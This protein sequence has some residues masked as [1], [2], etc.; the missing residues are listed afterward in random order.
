MKELAR[1][2][3]LLN[4][5]DQMYGQHPYIFHLDMV[6]NV[7]TLAGE[8]DDVLISAGYL[9][10][11]IEDTS[12]TYEII[13]EVFNK[14]IADI[15][16]AVS[17]AG[18]FEETA[19]NIDRAGLMAATVKTADRIANLIM[20]TTTKNTPTLKKYVSED[21]I[22]SAHVLKN[23]QNAGMISSYMELVKLANWMLEN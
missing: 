4:H 9:H 16:Q 21:S 14:R 8:I 5:K 11:T 2:I 6:V 10:D 23:V 7:L 22:F 1:T 12:M 17:N 20:S 15:V 18:S 13:A 19:A 3:A